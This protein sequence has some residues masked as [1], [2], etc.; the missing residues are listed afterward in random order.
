MVQV[1]V[2]MPARN[3]V[4]FI[5]QAIS[6]I[7]QQTDIDWEM[8]VVDDA[9]S[10]GTANAVGAFDDAR[11]RLVTND[12]R[13]GIGYCHNRV[14]AHSAAPYVAHVDADDFI[15]PGAL[16]KMVGALEEKPHAQAPGRTLRLRYWTNC[17]SRR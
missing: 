2:A 10:D 16:R 1:T 17:T 11:I 15:L 13:R 4:P 14:L 5:A 3:A 7:Q 12:R 6:S 8:I 9:S